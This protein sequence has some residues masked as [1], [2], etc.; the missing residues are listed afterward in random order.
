MA[1][2]EVNFIPSAISVKV[3]SGIT[4]S[5]AAAAAEINLRRSCF[6]KKLCGRCKVRILKGEV[7]PVTDDEKTR[8]SEDE[9]AHGFRLACKTKIVSNLEVDVPLVHTTVGVVIEKP[10]IMEE[11]AAEPYIYTYPMNLPPPSLNDNLGDL[12]R[13]I[14]FII[15]ENKAVDVQ[16]QHEFFPHLSGTLRDSGWRAGAVLMEHRSVPGRMNIID[17]L[18]IEPEKIPPLHSIALDIG[19]TT[20]AGY[21]L[22]QNSGQLVN[23]YYLPNPQG[24]YGSD[25]VTRLQF[26]KT[27]GEDGIT[28]LQD[29]ILAG[30]RTMISRLCERAKIDMGCIYAIVIAGNT[31]MQHLFLG[32]NPS[33]LA[34]APYSMVVTKYPVMDACQLDLMEIKHCSHFLPLINLP[35][36]AGYFGSDAVA[37]ALVARSYL[38]PDNSNAVICIDIGTNGEIVL[39]MPDGRI[40]GCSTAAG[41]AFEGAHIT[42]GMPASHGAISNLELVDDRFK[43]KVL[44]ENGSIVDVSEED[45]GICPVGFTGTAIIDLVAELLKHRFIDHTGKLVINDGTISRVRKGGNDQPEFVVL[46]QTGAAPNSDCAYKTDLTFTQEDIRQVQLA[47]GAI[48]A[49]IRTLIDHAGIEPASIRTV[50]L[51]GAFGSHINTDNVKTINLI[52]ALPGASIKTIGNAAGAGAVLASISKTKLREFYEIAAAIEYIE[53]ATDT[54]FNQLFVDSMGFATID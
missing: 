37:C 41:P 20:L 39:L 53:L 50:L 7:S 6:G 10:F 29:S 54:K 19:T 48:S 33:G 3:E 32:L 25:V 36:V 16:V 22:D 51:A 49:G 23:S 18:K 11:I 12:D 38:D 34:E 1:K 17:V 28:L 43:F 27:R 4:I 2:I 21:L 42:H 24:I 35:G 13:I 47:K 8:L 40:L 26:C 46:R 44:D 5:D 14:R 9:L 31:V 15:N 45:R 52:P 30:C